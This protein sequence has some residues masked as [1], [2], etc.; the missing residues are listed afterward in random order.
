MYKNPIA[1][2]KLDKIGKRNTEKLNRWL[3]Q[4]F[5]GSV[6]KIAKK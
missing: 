1:N 2:V 3:K 4:M 5:V 6:W